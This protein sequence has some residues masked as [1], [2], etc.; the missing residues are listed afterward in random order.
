M[1][2][3]KKVLF[4][5][6]FFFPEELSSAKIPYD[7]LLYL[8]NNHNDVQFE[9]LC[10]FQKNFLRTKKTFLESKAYDDINFKSTKI[11]R[12]RYLKINKNTRFAKIFNMLSFCLRCFF[13][14]SYIR[15][16]DIVFV[17]TNPPLLP[18]LVS[19]ILFG[20]KTKLLLICLDFYPYNLVSI[21]KLNKGLLL[22]FLVK[23][24]NYLFKK[25]YK[26]IAISENMLNKMLNFYPNYNSKIKVIHDWYTEEINYQLAVTNEMSKLRKDYK[27]IISY[28][29][30]MGLGQDI[31][32][33][34]Q[35]LVSFDS[36]PAVND[37]LF[38]FAGRGIKQIVLRDRLSLL[39]SL[40]YKI[41][42]YLYDND[43][44]SL[45]KISDLCIISL[46]EG[47]EGFGFPSKAY[48][49][50][51][52]SKPILSIMD[53]NTELSK[54]LISYRCGFSIKQGHPEKFIELL[55]KIYQKQINLDEMRS[56]TLTLYKSKYN[57]YM[58]LEKY[59][60][61]FSSLLKD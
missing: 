57:K 52:Y 32:T 43:Y 8:K 18:P 4:I 38:I 7:L 15:S 23:L 42:D 48:G 24:N 34:I 44:Q 21:N 59:G 12:L 54:D 36:N 41:F 37:F 17:Y 5:N 53:P 9:V 46:E 27:F 60:K 50:L 28:T 10:G 1:V 56:N 47:M 6:Q 19:V 31:N 20:K 58:S 61:L 29:G 51:S 22:F 2:H 49:Y 40:N 13:S 3:K 26:I 14:F 35:T 45:L 16:F 39:K 55:I 25:S 30:S 11:R 33:I